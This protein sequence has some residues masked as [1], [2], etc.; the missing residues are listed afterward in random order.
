VRTP[1]D[2]VSH[3][4]G[5]HFASPN[6]VQDLFAYLVV[7][8]HVTAIAEPT[9]KKCGFLTLSEDDTNHDFLRDLVVRP[10]E[11]DG[12]DGVA[13]EATISLLAKCLRKSLLQ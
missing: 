12:C 11:R 7:V 8:S 6:E 5:L 2:S 9:L 13:G 4:N 3:R 1:Y 10:I